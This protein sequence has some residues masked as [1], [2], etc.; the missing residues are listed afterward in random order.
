MIALR[1][2]AETRQAEREAQGQMMSTTSPRQPG[3]AACG[4]KK[5][6]GILAELEE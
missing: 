3:E 4:L 2:N 1:T 5:A 6:S